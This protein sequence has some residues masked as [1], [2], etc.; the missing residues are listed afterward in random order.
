MFQETELQALLDENDAQTQQELA[1][2]LGVARST[3]SDRLKAMGKIQKEAKWVPYE[4]NERQQGNRKTISEML[5][6]R[7]E[8]KSFLHRIVTEDEK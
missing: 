5:F 1:E 3:I 8:R 4:L 2:Q 6:A 7:Y